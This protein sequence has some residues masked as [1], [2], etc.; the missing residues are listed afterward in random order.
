MENLKCVKD[1]NTGKEY[2]IV[3]LHKD[4]NWIWKHENWIGDLSKIASHHFKKAESLS[5]K[6]DELNKLAVYEYFQELM[7]DLYAKELEASW[8]IEGEY[9]DSFAL[10]SALV[11]Q[12]CLNVPGWSINRELIHDDRENATVAAAL[13]FLNSKNQISIKE[14]CNIHGLLGYGDNK[15]VQ[16][17]FGELRTEGEVVG[18]IRNNNYEVIYEAPHPDDLPQLMNEYLSWW[19]KSKEILPAH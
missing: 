17:K 14:I 18:R 19:N 5:Q 2:P 3:F 7:T 9:L 16:G 4:R 10:R 15:K 11:K 1:Q 6:I 8:R 13:K 12:L